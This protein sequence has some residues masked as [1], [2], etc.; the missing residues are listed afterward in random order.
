MDKSCTVNEP[1]TAD[2]LLALMA[3]R[4]TTLP[5]RLV[6]PGPTEAQLHQCLAAAATA[7]DHQQLLPW[8]FVRIPLAQRAALGEALAQALT[9]RDP[10]ATDEQRVQAREKAARA[11]E[12]L[13]LV[14]DDDRGDPE[15]DVLERTLSAGCAVQ[16]LLL[17][18]TAL[19]YGSALTSGKGLKAKAVR[20]LF[21]LGPGEHA[22][23]FVSLGTPT[24]APLARP[25]P[26]VGDF[27]RTGLH[28]SDGG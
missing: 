10:T 26:A 4:R 3:A 23:C 9:E 27:L 17:A 19:G 14:V 18:A 5:K 16:N 7:P 15:V 8:R 1:A 24:R 11:P 13:L 20:D 22:V 25:R 21:G 2:D 28:G 6:A 12:L